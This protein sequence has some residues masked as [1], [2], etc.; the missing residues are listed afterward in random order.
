MEMPSPLRHLLLCTLCMAAGLS[1][2]QDIAEPAATTAPP[3]ASP[4]LTPPRP[5]DRTRNTPARYPAESK[6]KG[7]QGRV[8]VK[9]L[10]DAQGVATQAEIGRSSGHPQLDASALE[11]TRLWH[12]QPGRRNGI[13]EPMWTAVTINFVLQGAKPSPAE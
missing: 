7:E 1:A 4:D 11:A 13:P 8:E 3:A 6:R 12:Y 5:A 9:V 10:V 2:A